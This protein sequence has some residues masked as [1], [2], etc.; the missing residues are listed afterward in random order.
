MASLREAPTGVLVTLMIKMQ[1][2][3]AMMLLMWLFGSFKIK[4]TSMIFTD[5]ERPIIRV[6]SNLDEGLTKG[7]R[8]VAPPPGPTG[9][10]MAYI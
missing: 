4:R 10:K 6:V 8:A 7:E 9:R 2:M 1:A 3:L 5:S